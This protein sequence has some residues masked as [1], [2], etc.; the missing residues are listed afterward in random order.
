[1][2][3]KPTNEVDNLELRT[4]ILELSTK[5]ILGHAAGIQCLVIGY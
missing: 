2:N 4:W 3:L 5:L 1:M